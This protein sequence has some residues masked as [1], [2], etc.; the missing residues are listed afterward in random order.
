[1]TYNT[2]GQNQSAVNAV[3]WTNG[4]GLVTGATIATL[5]TGIIGSFYLYAPLSGATFTGPVSAPSFT[6]TIASGVMVANADPTGVL[7]S[8]A[9]INAAAALSVGG[10]IQNVILPSGTFLIS[11]QLNIGSPTASQCLVGQGWGTV[12]HVTVAFN[13]S[14]NGVVNLSGTSLNNVQPCVKNLQIQFDQPTDLQTTA[15]AGTIAGSNIV[16]VSSTAGIANGMIVVDVT[17]SSAIPNTLNNGVLALPTVTNISGN[18]VTISQN[19]SSPGISSGDQIDFAQPRANFASL[20]SCSS[21]SGQSGCKYPWAIYAGSNVNSPYIDNVQIRGA[22]NGTYIRGSQFHIGT[23]YTG[24]F[25]VGIDIDNCYNFPSVDNYLFWNFGINDGNAQ[26]SALS[27][28]YYD[29]STVAANIGR[30]D[31]ISWGAL[32]TWAGIVNI[33]T[34]FTFG[35]IH[36]L[37]LDGANA[38]INV[39]ASQAGFLMVGEFYSTKPSQTYGSPVYVNANSAFDVEIANLNISSASPYN[40]AVILAGG[41]LGLKGG[42]MWDGQQASIPMIKQQGG[43]LRISNMAFDAGASRTDTYILQS[44]GLMQLGTNNAF[45][46]SPGT[47]AV[48][49]SSSG[50]TYR[51]DA[52]IYW[53]GWTHP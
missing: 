16:T 20:G 2:P 24:A 46:Q 39:T 9:A 31:G 5:L 23:L 53:N 35:A 12:L 37:F 34:S 17:H 4:K 11:N 22:W 42:Y 10:V 8:S 51:E 36:Q 40:T 38:D 6:G 50:G 15:S 27:L 19:V 49:F 48:G 52:Q 28:N 3:P 18:L 25:N 1:M 29:G 43:V 44:S 21:S 47:G 7:D 14:A 26:Q 41:I 45:I 30:T 33:E 32:Q 13:P